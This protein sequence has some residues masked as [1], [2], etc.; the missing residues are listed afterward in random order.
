M[1]LS[2]VEPPHL[3]PYGPRFDLF[4]HYLRVERGLSPNTVDN[5]ALDLRSYLGFLASRG[6]GEFREIT[7]A[8]VREHLS[9]LSDGGLGSRSLARHL[10]AIKTLHRHLLEEDELEADPAREVKPPR[11]AKKLPE[12]LS[13]PEV[14][15]LLEVPDPATARG[16]RDRAMLELMYACGLRVSELCGLRL[17]DVRRDPGLVRVLGKGSKERLVPVGRSAITYLER[18]LDQARGQLLRDRESPYLFVGLRR[19]RVSRAAFWRDLRGWALRAGI[20]KTVSPHKLRHSFATHLLQGGADLR[21][22]QAMLGHASIGTTQ[23]YTHVDRGGLR[24]THRRFHP[25]G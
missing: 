1:T 4:L 9:T 17:G 25:R 3:G 11:Q 22:V 23:I 19:P 20:R 24:E 18:Y 15:A 10:S 2:A 16:Q 7:E 12:W 8:L 5:Y 13:L 21:A 14:D 6:V